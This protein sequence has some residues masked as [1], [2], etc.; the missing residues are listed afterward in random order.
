MTRQYIKEMA[1]KNARVLDSKKGIKREVERNKPSV[2][3]NNSGEIKESYFINF[4]YDTRDGEVYSSGSGLSRKLITDFE[5]GLIGRAWIEVEKRANQNS[6]RIVK[7]V[8]LDDK[9]SLHKMTGTEEYYLEEIEKK[10]AVPN[11]SRTAQEILNTLLETILQYNHLQR[12][13]RNQGVRR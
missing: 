1:R 12:K 4:T 9:L 6:L 3:E 7:F 11:V 2:T 8:G 13:K 5:N 10:N